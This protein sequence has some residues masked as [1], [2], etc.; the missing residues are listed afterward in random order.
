MRLGKDKHEDPWRRPRCD[1]DLFFADER[2]L[3][4]S[5]GEE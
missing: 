4:T 2:A 1:L 3:G 5:L